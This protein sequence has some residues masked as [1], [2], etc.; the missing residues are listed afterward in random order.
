MVVK[1]RLASGGTIES[2]KLKVKNYFSYGCGDLACNLVFS[3]MSAFLLF[4]YTN[5]IGVSAAAAGTVMFISKFLDGVSDL[6]AG[7]II[8][9]TKSKYGKAR[10]WL[11]RMSLPFAVGATLLFSVPMGWSERGQIIYI[12]VTYNLTFTVI[13]TA[14]NLPYSTMNALMTQ[15]QYERSVLNIYR[16]IFA[17]VG[18]LFV[19]TFTLPV[20]NFFGNDA[21]AWTYTFAT[22]GI[23]AA[24]LLGIT[25]L[26]CEERVGT[27]LQPNH[28]VSNVSVKEGMKSLLKNKYWIK[29]TL[30][31]VLIFMTMGV[32]NGATIYFAESILGNR[33][34]VTQLSWALNITQ[35]LVMLMVAP[36]IKRHGKRNTMLSGM[37]ISIVAYGMMLL[38]PTHT[39]LIFVA[40]IIRGIG[41]ACIASCMFAMVSDTIEYG[42]WKTNVR[43]EGLIN[44]GSSFGFK[45]GI[46]LGSA[47]VGWVLTLGGYMGDAST[48]TESAKLAIKIL[49]IFLPMVLTIIQIFVMS[50][51]KLDK[52]YPQ[53]IKD[54][55]LRHADVKG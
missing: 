47:I 48:Q 5:V 36:F 26:G 17:T 30:T 23:L 16:M 39:T 35:V 8:D 13:Y 24:I 37:V 27:H 31:L 20:V 55:K 51:Y 49:Y 43:T 25:F 32:T 29:V 9:R 3:A 14:I 18:T 52:E 42:E 1:K 50:T 10:P 15:D 22:F 45:V 6:F 7:F 28:E 19:T 12:F 21:T 2:D 4:Y 38:S 46:G 53:I 41:G 44:S 40:N 54:L 33:E 34:F 11:I